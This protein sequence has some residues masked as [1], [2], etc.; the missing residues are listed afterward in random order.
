MKFEKGKEF[1]HA[2]TSIIKIVDGIFAY[3][4]DLGL[5]AHQQEQINLERL[6][7]LHE[8]FIDELKGNIENYRSND[9]IFEYLH[10]CFDNFLDWKGFSSKMTD[11]IIIRKQQY[12]DLLLILKKTVEKYHIMIGKWFTLDV[13]SSDSFKRMI[14]FRCVLAEIY[15][16]KYL[17]EYEL[18]RNVEDLKGINRHNVN[19]Q[20]VDTDFEFKRIKSLDST[21]I[22]YQWNASDTDL[23]ELSTALL[24]T[25]AITRQDGK[26]MTHKE[27]REA[28][29]KLFDHPIKDAK[30][31]LATA[32]TRKKSV[33]PFLDSLVD[34]FETYSRERDEK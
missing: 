14:S 26:K 4:E 2:L 34:A 3:E 15:K 24:R 29:E 7:Q 23:L 19:D 5:N 6:N 10:I 30:G 8:D 25:Q 16:M 28:F 20:E 27:M 33:T 17:P 21:T 31:K 11:A 12:V 13:N 22:L 18:L 32:V 9:Y 1:A